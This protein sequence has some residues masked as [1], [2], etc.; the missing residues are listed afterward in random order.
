MDSLS[1]G[2]HKEPG[3]PR[4]G[5]LPKD[6]HQGRGRPC[7]LAHPTIPTLRFCRNHSLVRISS[8]PTVPRGSLDM[9]ARLPDL[10]RECP[11]GARLFARFGQEV[12]LLCPLVRR[13]RTCCAPTVSA[14][15]P[16]M[17][18]QCPYCVLVF[19]E[20]VLLSVDWVGGSYWLRHC[21]C[22]TYDV[23]DRKRVGA[24]LSKVALAARRFDR[25]GWGGCGV[26][27]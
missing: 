13:T 6:A 26:R 7:S 5:S 22:V 8:A 9:P 15:S 18:M 20:Q 25:V 3:R 16:H 21:F 27:D 1:S 4:P 19:A 12:P 24:A 14:R 10:G 11:Y 23:S 2:E 17:G